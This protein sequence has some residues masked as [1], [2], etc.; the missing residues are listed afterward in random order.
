MTA[1]ERFKNW[2]DETAKGFADRLKDWISAVLAWGLE[3]VMDVIAKSAAPKLKP[4]IDRIE[5]EAAIPPE[6]KPLFDELKEPTGEFGA[7]LAD[8]AGGAL[9]GG[10]IGKILDFLLRPLTLGFSYVPGF[11][12]LEV[13]QLLA[14]W[15]RGKITDDELNGRLHQLGLGGDTIP[16]L[17]SLIDT[18]LDPANWITAFRRKYEDFS[19]IED[20]LK[21]Q[22]W[23][24]DRIEAL[25]FVTLYYPGPTEVMTWAAREV[26]EPELR[27]K[28]QLDKFMPPEF[29]EWAEKAGITGEVADNYWAAHW[30]LP[31]IS[32]VTELWRRKIWDKETVDDFWTELDMVPWVREDLFKLFRAIPT[33][34]DVRRFWD[35]R[36]IDE[37]RLRDIYQAMGYWEEDLEDYV[38]WTKVYVAFPDLMARWSKGWISLDDVRKELTDLGMDPERLEEFIQMKVKSTEPERVE[39]ERNLTKTD[40][41]K[42]VKTGAITRGE[43]AELLMDLGFDADEADFLLFINIP[44]DEEDEVVAQ[45]ALTKADILKGLKTEVITREQARDRLLDLRYSPTDAEFLLKIYDAQVKP[46]VEPREREAS[47]ADILLGVKKGLITP[48]EGYGM[49]LDLDFTPEAADFI[50]MVKA[51]ESP[52]SPINFAEFKDLTQKYRRAAGMGVVEMPEEIKTAASLVVTLTGDVEAL[53]RSIAEEKRGLIEGEAIPE[54]KTK[55]LKSLQVKRNRAISKLSAAKSEYDRLVAEWRH[56]LP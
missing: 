16:E 28:F 41:Y 47:K 31:S 34:V 11:V 15:R 18:R 30:A 56:G 49:L 5:K 44:R 17:K 37:T 40:I 36:T 1:G 2:V 19:K 22:G 4:M 12:L 42:G 38:L 25:K 45:R 52:F 9:V 26:F 23:S 35:M 21:H 10:A 43:A 51:E 20:D 13:P 14:L 7:L 32:E 53:E 33:R 8:S 39:S 27:E 24:E 46:P 3:I 48:E 55:R 6:L 54:E 29:K 50:L